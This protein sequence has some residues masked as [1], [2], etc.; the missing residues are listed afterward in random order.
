[1]DEKIKKSFEK[2]KKVASSQEK[3]L[4]KEDIKRDKKC[5]HAEEMAKRRK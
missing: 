4:V 1:M 2:V 3:K 5:E